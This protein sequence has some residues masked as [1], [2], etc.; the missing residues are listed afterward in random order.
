MS[1]QLGR[2]KPQ[3]PIGRVLHI[4]CE[5]LKS[6][7]YYLQ[8]YTSDRQLGKYI[9]LEPHEHTDP[10]NLVND[11]K[12]LKEKSPANDEFWVVY[13]SESIQQRDT[14]EHKLA[15]Q[16]AIKSGINIALSCV[17]FET[18]ILLHHTYPESRIKR[19]LFVGSPFP[20]PNLLS[21]S[22]I[23]LLVSTFLIFPV[24]LSP[25]MPFLKRVFQIICLA[26]ACLLHFNMHVL[27]TYAHVK[28]RGLQARF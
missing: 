24:L 2:R 4:F 3:R 10:R 14:N 6:A 9:S 5:D 27:L 15:W 19:T 7:R 11:A 18:W 23:L 17:S 13:D 25:I 16:D 20:V 26:L 22:R 12:A 1:K 28:S 21:R 8:G